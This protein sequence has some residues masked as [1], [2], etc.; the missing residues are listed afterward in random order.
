MNISEGIAIKT[1]VQKLWT[2]SL[3][4]VKQK[5]TFFLA[6]SFVVFAPSVAAAT[7]YADSV[8]VDTTSA[9]SFESNVPVYGKSSMN[10]SDSSADSSASSNTSDSA[11]SSASASAKTAGEN[12][13]ETEVVVNGEK[14]EV[15]PNSRVESTTYG[16]DGSTSSVSISVHSNQNNTAATNGFNNTHIHSFTN[17]NSQNSIITNTFNSNNHSSP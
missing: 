9:R 1:K 8:N 11:S 7:W 15:L 14:I 2:K 10:F 12:K 13:V 5:R 6:A 17:T 3:Y 16:S 4:V